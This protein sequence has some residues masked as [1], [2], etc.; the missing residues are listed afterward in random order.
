VVR[1]EAGENSG[2]ILALEFDHEFKIVAL[3]S[4]AQQTFVAEGSCLIGHSVCV[5]FP[6]QNDC[7]GFLADIVAKIKLFCATRFESVCMDRRGKLFH[8]SIVLAKQSLPGK[9]YFFYIE[10]MKNSFPDFNNEGNWI[11]ANFN[12]TVGVDSEIHLDKNTGFVIITD[13]NLLVRYCSR[14]FVALTAIKE[15][16]ILDNDLCALF[17]NDNQDF[18]RHFVNLLVANPG[19]AQ[20]IEAIDLLNE[21]KTTVW[22]D[23]YATNL[24]DW[25]LVHGIVFNI[26]D[27]TPRIEAR[28][29]LRKANDI[30]SF[31]GKINELLSNLDD[32]QTLFDKFNLLAVTH[33]RFEMAFICKPMKTAK[34]AEV[35]SSFN[36]TAADLDFF[37]HLMLSDN[38]PTESVILTGKPFI[39]NNFETDT[40]N[41]M[42]RIYARKKGVGSCIILPLR[43]SGKT[44]YTL[45]LFTITPYYFQNDELI[46]LNDTANDISLVLELFEKEKLRAEIET[47]LNTRSLVLEKTEQISHNGSCEIDIANGESVW[48]LGMC[49]LLDTRVEKVSQGIDFWK[50][51]V[52]PGDLEEV[53]VKINEV[54]DTGESQF[55]IHRIKQPGGEVRHLFTKCHVEC[56]DNDVYKNALHIICHDVTDEFLNIKKLEKQNEKLQEISWT[57]SHKLR[58]PVA[59]ILGLVDLLADPDI[60]AEESQELVNCL[61]IAATELDHT[62]IDIVGKSQEIEIDQLR[63]DMA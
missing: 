41:T 16:F 55:F 8:V 21:K 29:K 26:Y 31:K 17:N 22:V 37:A 2:G 12:S 46:L 7:T 4:E 39:V 9:N 5:I 35:I 43:L 56:D 40:K 15:E 18:F 6:G 23:I 25:P 20:K 57:Q 27:V 13:A 45:H 32:K 33:G 1:T 52:H 58:G 44:L 11:S 63:F 51:F 3:N 54:L 62:T 30:L 61:K 10:K 38:G 53:S 49:R 34:R 36:A 19:K 59:T 48:S 47:K 60:S 24:L 42:M 28:I 50:S 14:S